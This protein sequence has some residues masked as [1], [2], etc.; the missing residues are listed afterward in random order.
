MNFVNLTTQ[1]ESFEAPLD[2]SGILD[3]EEPFNGVFIRAPVSICSVGR[4]F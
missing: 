3:A 2:V 4:H 1:L